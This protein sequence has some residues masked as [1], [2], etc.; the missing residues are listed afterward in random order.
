MAA[1]REPS[2][3]VTVAETNGDATVSNGAS[4]N[5]NGLAPTEAMDVDASADA[6][7]APTAPE[8]RLSTGLSYHC[9]KE[10]YRTGS[11]DTRIARSFR[12]SQEHFTRK[13]F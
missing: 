11:L 13:S 5:E 6:T 3:A 2:A 9:T 7:A 1:K 12:Q 4:A 10:I 8:V